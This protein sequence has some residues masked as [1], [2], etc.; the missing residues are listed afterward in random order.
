MKEIKKIKK[1]N[2][3]YTGEFSCFIVTFSDDEISS[4]PKDEMNMD[5]QAILQWVADGN[6]IEEAD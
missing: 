6:T 5:Y 1:V 3:F 2:D 4:V